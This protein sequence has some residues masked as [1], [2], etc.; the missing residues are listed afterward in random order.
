LFSSQ[1]NESKL[2]LL[3]FKSLELILRQLDFGCHHA[4]IIK[5]LST[6][7]TSLHLFG[8]DRASGGLLGAIGLGKRSTLSPA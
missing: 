8:E 1:E 3:W 2:L 7:V 5:M 4:T 6:M